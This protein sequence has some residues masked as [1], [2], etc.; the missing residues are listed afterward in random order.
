MNAHD[1]KFQGIRNNLK[2]LHQ[3]NTEVSYGMPLAVSRT[4]AF[5]H[6]KGLGYNFVGGRPGGSKLHLD[7]VHVF[8]PEIEYLFGLVCGG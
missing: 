8:F 4:P 1:L 2:A 3:G 6:G 5:P 7:R